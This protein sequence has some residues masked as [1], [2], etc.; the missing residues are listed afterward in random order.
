[1]T[2]KPCG[3]CRRTALRAKFHDPI[4]RRLRAAQGDEPIPSGPTGK[5][6]D[7][8]VGNPRFLCIQ[9]GM[10]GLQGEYSGK[11]RR[12]PDRVEFP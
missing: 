10:P 6:I 1:M 5:K 11:S 4:A 9:L 3:I 2:T 7:K 8:D 12:W